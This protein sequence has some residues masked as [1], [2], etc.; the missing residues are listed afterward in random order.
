MSVS[1]DSGSGHRK[2]I[3]AQALIR[4]TR[5]SAHTPLCLPFLLL[6]CFVCARETLS[7]RPWCIFCIN[8]HVL[9]WVI[10]RLHDYNPAV[11]E[12]E[13]LRRVARKVL[14]SCKSSG[15]TAVRAYVAD[16][17]AVLARND[18]NAGTRVWLRG[19]VESCHAVRHLNA[20]K[21]RASGCGQGYGNRATEGLDEAEE[22]SMDG[23]Q[24][25]GADDVHTDKEDEGGKALCSTLRRKRWR[26]CGRFES[27]SQCGI[28]EEQKLFYSTTGPEAW[29]SGCVPYL[30]SSSPLLGHTYAVAI[31]DFITSQVRTGP[32]HVGTCYVIEL[33]AGLC[34]LG[35]CALLLLL[36]ASDLC[37]CLHATMH[38]CQHPTCVTSPSNPTQIPNPKPQTPNTKA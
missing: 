3:V 30:I 2:R 23:G 1:A 32:P 38:N 34:K 9:N 6:R 10:N 15:F 18:V 7:T 16:L 27:L 11:L 14:P 31:Y 4:C 19:L 5:D 35:A 26:G 22:Q 28:W 37:R 21:K 33:G 17:E 25:R 12:S 36:L 13:W 8:T 24:T 29:A 20:M